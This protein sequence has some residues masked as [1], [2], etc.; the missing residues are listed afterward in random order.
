MRKIEDKEIKRVFD[1]YFKERMSSYSSPIMLILVEPFFYGPFPYSDSDRDS[2]VAKFRVS[3][4]PDMAYGTVDIVS[5]KAQ[6]ESLLF[7]TGKHFLYCYFQISLHHI[8]KPKNQERFC[9]ESCCLCALYCFSEKG[10]FTAGGIH[11]IEKK[12]RNTF[13]KM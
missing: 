2:D 4:K 9:Q 8:L 5:L 12:S 6:H 11:D 7:T 10:I 3:R 1:G 13:Q